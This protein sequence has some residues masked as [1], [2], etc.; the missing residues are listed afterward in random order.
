MI[1]S[2]LPEPCKDNAKQI[3]KVA[4]DTMDLCENIEVDN[5][6]IQ[7]KSLIQHYRNTAMKSFSNLLLRCCI[8]NDRNSH[9][10]G[11]HWCHRST[12]TKILFIWE[13]CEPYFS[14]R[15]YWNSRENKCV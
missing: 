12:H 4:L 2:G 10:R 5:E 13:Y 14:M 1:V 6:K 3:C 8:D 15:D 9:W 11:R 7:V